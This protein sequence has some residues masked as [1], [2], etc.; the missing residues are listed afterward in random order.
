VAAFLFG[1]GVYFSFFP[2]VVCSYF[3][4]YMY[5]FVL[6]FGVIKNDDDDDD[7]V[8][9]VLRQWCL[10]SEAARELA[11]NCGIWRW[12]ERSR[13]TLTDCIVLLEHAGQFPQRIESAIQ[14]CL[15]WTRQ[16]TGSQYSWIRLRLTRSFWPIWKNGRVA[17][18]CTHCSPQQATILYSAEL[19]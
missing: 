14:H 3:V 18:F 4:F 15:F 2:R 10:C 11:R 12:P 16:R 1:H 13:L 7:E 9:V 19:Q 8:C 6:R 5:V 17:A